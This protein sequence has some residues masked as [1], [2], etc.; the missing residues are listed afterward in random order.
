MSNWKM[1]TFDNIEIEDKYGLSK[2]RENKRREYEYRNRK[3]NV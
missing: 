1:N 3:I 2:N